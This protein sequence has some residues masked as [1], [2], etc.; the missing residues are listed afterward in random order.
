MAPVIP[1]MC[2]SQVNLGRH[3]HKEW[4]SLANSKDETLTDQNK[5]IDK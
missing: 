4:F 1:C 3:C 5:S 2:P